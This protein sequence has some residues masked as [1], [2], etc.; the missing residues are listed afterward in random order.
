[1]RR[2]LDDAEQNGHCRDDRHGNHD[3]DCHGTDDLGNNGVWIINK[4]TEG[5]QMSYWYKET[6]VHDYVVAL[7]AEYNVSIKNEDQMPWEAEDQAYD[8]IEE[9]LKKN[10]VEEYDIYTATEMETFGG[11]IIKVRVNL[12]VPAVA[13]DYDEAMSVAETYVDNI[14][15]P[16]CVHGIS[17]GTWDSALKEEKG[18]L[19]RCKGA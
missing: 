2:C 5:E 6:N 9:V 15:F 1:M 10:D 11:Y 8:I 4:I 18:F 17:I 14:T 13:S 19:M 16:E 7:N 3:S 12:I